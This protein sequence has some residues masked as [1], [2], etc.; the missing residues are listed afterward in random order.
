[1]KVDGQIRLQFTFIM[2]VITYT[3]MAENCY[4]LYNVFTQQTKSY[5]F[6]QISLMK[7]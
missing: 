2:I 3:H 6:T 5:H 7:Y 1:M 4:I